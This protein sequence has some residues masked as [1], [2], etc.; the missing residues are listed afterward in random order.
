M[1]ISY[2]HAIK[3]HSQITNGTNK[4]DTVQFVTTNLIPYQSYNVVIVSVTNVFPNGF[5]T[6]TLAPHAE[7]NAT[8]TT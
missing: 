5:R 3:Y 4:M 7:N 8:K 6:K 2:Y 1:A